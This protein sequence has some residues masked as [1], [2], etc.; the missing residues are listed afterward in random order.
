MCC[1]S[2]NDLEQGITTAAESVDGNM[3]RCAWDELDCR[4]DICRVTGG[5]YIEHSYHTNLRTYI[6]NSVS[7]TLVSTER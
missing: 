3:L 1:A 7:A 5:S 2:V 6:R 4:I